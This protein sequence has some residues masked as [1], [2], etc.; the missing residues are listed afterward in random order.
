MKT[1]G[2]VFIGM[3]IYGLGNMISVMAEEDAELLSAGELLTNC[4]EGH[5]PGAPNQYCMRYVF[6]LVQMILSLQQA[7]QSAPIFCID[8]QVIRLEKVTENVIAYLRS[9]SDRGNEAAQVLVAEAL[10]K[11]YPCPAGGNRT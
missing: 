11:N 7:D 3:I 9:Q 10:N 1:L 4:E 6:G 5:V 8:P 2:T